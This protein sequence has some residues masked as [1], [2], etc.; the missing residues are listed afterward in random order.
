MMRAA[1]I[2]AVLALSSGVALAQA[3]PEEPQP[4][5]CVAPA[6]ARELFL[7]KAL[8]PPIRAMRQAAAGSGAE[9]IDIQLCFFR[10]ALVYD[11]TLLDRNGAVTH[12][13]MSATTGGPL[14]ER[15]NP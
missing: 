1:L 8:L 14:G 9:A 2:G 3:P 6:K 12:R 7:Q 11:V 15:P 10:G 5:L 13:L 4:L